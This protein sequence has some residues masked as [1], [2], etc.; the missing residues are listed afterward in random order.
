MRRMGARTGC[1]RTLRERRSVAMPSATA[2]WSAVKAVAANSGALTGSPAH[3]YGGG[4]PLDVRLYQD[5]HAALS[6]SSV[7]LSGPSL[8]TVANV[9]FQR[10]TVTLDPKTHHA[11][12]DIHVMEVKNQKLTIKQTFKGRKPADTAQFCD[13]A[14]NPDDNKQYE[15][16][17]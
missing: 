4:A 12:L 5:G 15:V 11:T 14:K 1:S 6:G 8:D 3:T 9:R 17:I 7:T 2:P 16:K 10:G 13:L